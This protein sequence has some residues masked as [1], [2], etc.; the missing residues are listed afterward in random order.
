MIQKQS[1]I[2]INPFG[3]LSEEESENLTS[4]QEPEVVEND[5]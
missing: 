3:E 4:K 2:K 5:S 1:P